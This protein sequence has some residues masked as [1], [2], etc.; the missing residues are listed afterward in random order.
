MSIPVSRKMDLTARAGIW[1]LALLVTGVFA[2]ILGEIIL[3]GAPGLGIA[4]VLEDPID[5]GRGGGIRSILWA[6]FLIM[7]VCLAVATPV[8]VA[9]GI[10]LAEFTEKFRY[11]APF[12]RRSL[13][14]LAGV[15]SIV[16]GLFGNAFFAVYLGLGFSILAGGLTLAIMILPFLIRAVETSLRTIPAEIRLVGAA[17]ALSR[18]TLIFRVLL[19]AALPGLAAGLV[20]ALG[21]AMAET[22]ALIFTSGYVTRFPESFLD[23]GRALSVHILD[24]ALNIPGGTTNAYRSALVLVAFLACINFLFFRLSATLH[25]RNQG[26]QR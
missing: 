21:R 18:T 9:T 23:S 6:T 14:T 16:Y 17:L 10:L 11:L 25:R 3:N 15:P 22:A 12:I 26:S 2:A 13:D 24:L 1:G 8:A 20:L 7:V 5:A 4:F 19:P